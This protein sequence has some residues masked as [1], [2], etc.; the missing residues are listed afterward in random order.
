MSTTIREKEEALFARWAKAYF[1]RDGVGCDEFAYDGV[2]FRGEC[3]YINGCWEMQPG[4]ETQL[5]TNAKCRLLILTK[6]TT[7]NGGMD[8][9]RIESIRKNHMGHIVTTQGI[10]FYRNLTLWAYALINALNG[11]EILPYDDT[12]SW[13]EL[14]EFYCSAPIARVNCKKQ[15]GTSSISNSELKAHIYRY[16]DFLKEQ[17]IMYDANILLCCGGSGLIKDF[18]KECYLPDMMPFSD[19]DWVYFSPSTRKIVINS[20]HPSFLM[21]SKDMYSAMM[22]DLKNFLAAHPYFIV[23]SRE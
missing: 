14:R 8:D 1:E 6:D 5:W 21:K 13:N 18:I 2:L 19:A 11:G 4:N 20:Y 12:P 10:T 22:L 16:A 7:L 15:I 23:N 17:I 3:K 9:I